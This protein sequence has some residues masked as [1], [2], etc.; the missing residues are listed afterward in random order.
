MEKNDS[1]FTIDKYHINKME[2]KLFRVNIFMPVKKF[3]RL[4][5]LL[6]CQRRPFWIFG[7]FRGFFK[8][9]NCQ[10]WEFYTEKER[11]KTLMIKVAKSCH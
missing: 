1:K 3:P 4:L 2:I 11:D 9:I 10:N 7:Q 6:F 8:E 5:I